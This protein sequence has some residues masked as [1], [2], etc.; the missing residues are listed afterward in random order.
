MIVGKSGTIHW[1]SSWKCRCRHTT[2]P[3]HILP[4]SEKFRCDVA[5]YWGLNAHA[6]G[7]KNRWNSQDPL[8]SSLFDLWIS[9]S[10]VLIIKKPYGFLLLTF[11]PSIPFSSHWAS[12]QFTQICNEGCRFFS[13]P[14][15]P[16]HLSAEPGGVFSNALRFLLQ[17]D[18]SGRSWSWGVEQC[19]RLSFLPGGFVWNLKVKSE[20][21]G[22]QHKVI[23]V[24]DF[25]SSCACC[26]P[27]PVL[28]RLE[29]YI[30]E[31]VPYLSAETW[32]K[33]PPS[34]FL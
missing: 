18:P 33:N 2:A 20:T 14:W 4:P 31:V 25:G 5:A 22:Q 7:V 15:L 34:A 29:L 23:Q 10:K 26:V 12:K 19:C 27:C 9:K 32:V 3:Y 1:Y 24:G 6:G 11:K 30:L 17:V 16:L 28:K 13:L 8:V 21:K